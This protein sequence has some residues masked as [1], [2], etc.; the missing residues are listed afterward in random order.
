[1]NFF[2]RLP[3]RRPERG[4]F[5][6]IELMIVVAVLAILA[7]IAIPKFGE[8][9]LRSKESSAKGAL[10]TFRSAIDI[11]YV[12]N[13]GRFPDDV[14][15]LTEAKYIDFLP[16]VQIPP[17]PA[18]NNPGHSENNGVENYD[19]EALFGTVNEGVVMW[20]YVSTGIA[21]GHVGFNCTHRDT[22]GTV[23]SSL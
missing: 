17:V 15:I 2:A 22:K 8:L 11:Y 6:L 20:A 18:E 7:A 16:Q 9:I 13:E 3:P 1:M 19:D 14:N 23:W 12:D 21:A 5:T 10:G 4:G